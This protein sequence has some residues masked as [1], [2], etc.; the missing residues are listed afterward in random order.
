V[1]LLRNPILIVVG[2]LAL[3]LIVTLG[4]T[5]KPKAPEANVE[6]NTI[7]TTYAINTLPDS[8]TVF[9]VT[10]YWRAY[11]ID[12]QA[13]FYRYWI[14]AADVPDNAKTMTYDT[15]AS[16]QLD[17]AT[18][19]DVYTFNV[20]AR[21]D[22]DLWD[23]TPAVIQIN[24]ADTRHGSVF[25][26]NTTAGT[27]PPDGA[28]TSRGVHLVI[29]GLDLDGSVASFQRAVDNT[30]SWVNVT[31]QVVLEHQS[32]VEMNITGLL[33]GPHIVYVR[34]IDNM[35][36]IDDSPLSIS[37]VVVDTLRPDLSV[38]A[39]AIPNAFYFLPQGGTETDIPTNWSADAT[40][41]YSTLQ[42]RYAVD[43][44]SQWS[45]LQTESNA[46]LTGLGAGSHQ[47]FIQAIDLAGNSTTMITDFGVGSLT[48]DLGILLVNGIDWGTYSPQPE[49]MYA[50]NGPVGNHPFHFWDFF[51]GSS[52]YYPENIDSVYIGSGA[53]PGD[54]MGHY[55][56]VVFTI[57]D[58]NG[59]Y[60]IFNSM[61]PLILSYLNGGGNVL[62]ATRFGSD[63]I[64][65]DLATYGL[66]DGN[67]LTF[68]QIGVNPAPGGLVA[69][70]DGLVDI[71]SLGSW[72]LSD[73][74]APS[75]DPAVTTIFTTPDFSSAV[76]G[77]IVEPEGKGRFVF[78][79]GREYR[80]EHT[81]M[82]TDF[83][84]ILTHYF[85]EQ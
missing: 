81:A 37:F 64:K 49:E 26:P 61:A 62:L 16:M 54:V 25:N 39:G 22:R 29:N 55:S 48:G 13:E 57:N 78:I 76:G 14:G 34:A 72:S 5:E 53:V 83:D 60:E 52:S 58:F 21:D 27:V 11:D 56:S 45:P 77:I 10:V 33:P 79:A 24:M 17:F 12:G 4:C 51:S 36:N 84:Y 40:W 59:D 41:Y 47:F 38:V 71:T 6:P 8:G 50:A 9:T 31:P 44:S 19:A 3:A 85:G 46:T 65:G 7:I 23:S 32:T 42:F 2:L 20:Q 1:N 80:F 63:F 15:F 74:L 35:G 75:D 28:L 30:N 43:D 18:Q 67:S 68:D 82:A 66:S 69:A 70:V 73:L